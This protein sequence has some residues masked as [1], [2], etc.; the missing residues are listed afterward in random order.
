MNDHDPLRPAHPVAMPSEADSG[1]PS[2]PLAPAAGELRGTTDEAPGVAAA[3]TGSS[4]STWSLEKAPAV[5]AAR[6]AADFVA[7]IF[8]E[9]AAPEPAPVVLPVAAQDGGE[10]VADPVQAPAE[11]VGRPGEEMKPLQDQKILILGLGASGLAMVRWC[12]RCGAQVTVADTREAPPQLAALQQE[13]P[14][15]RFVAG[16]FGAHLVQ[17]Q[18]LHAV[19]RS[20][21][22]SP[23]SVAP[24]FIAASALLSWAGAC[25]C[26]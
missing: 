3:G 17:G 2:A 23:D 19:Y 7:Q 16:A 6:A 14:Q 24:V 22:L 11:P 20:P 21:G 10:P 8:A 26:L 4:G 12:V 1:A 15:V 25:F 5:S 13:L 9:V 18:D